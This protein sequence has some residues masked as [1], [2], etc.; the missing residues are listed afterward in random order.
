MPRRGTT[1]QGT[2]QSSA[3]TG[4]YYLNSRYYDANTGRFINADGYIQTGQGLL[5]KNMFAYCENN[6]V[7]F[8]DENGEF[9]IPF[10][11][12]NILN[13]TACEADY[14]IALQCDSNLWLGYNRTVVDQAIK[15]AKIH[16][17]SPFMFAEHHKRGTTNPANREKHEN[18]NARRQRDNGGEKKNKN[19]S[20]KPNPNK[21]R[22][23]N[24]E[25]GFSD[26]I[27]YGAI[28]LGATGAV[29]Y[30]LANDVT[31]VGVIDDAYIAPLLP[32]I[33]DNTVKCFA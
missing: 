5:D 22:N 6:P 11:A 8:S 15:M 12:E 3:D 31:G 16:E 23:Q 18:A 32:I 17:N 1:T 27:A 4:L 24:I 13:G 29:V 26:R 9:P 19:P 30:L 7:N 14:N 25:I 21:R 2:Y 28:A 20:W 33:W 10:W